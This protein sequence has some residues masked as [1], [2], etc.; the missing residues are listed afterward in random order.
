MNQTIL[1]TVLAE[2]KYRFEQITFKYTVELSKLLNNFSAKTSNVLNGTFDFDLEVLRVRELE[3]KRETFEK[4]LKVYYEY[5]RDFINFYLNNVKNELE[6]NVKISDFSYNMF[7]NMLALQRQFLSLLTEY[8]NIYNDLKQIASHEYNIYSA[9]YKQQ[10]LSFNTNTLNLKKDY[11]DISIS[12][13]EK[14]LQQKEAYISI[15]AENIYRQL[16]HKYNFNEALL[17]ME[18]QKLNY[19]EKLVSLLRQINNYKENLVNTNNSALNFYEKYLYTIDEFIQTLR[20][21]QHLD[22]SIQETE[23]NKRELIIEQH[24][25]SLYENFYNIKRNIIQIK[26]SNLATYINNFNSELQSRVSLLN[27]EFS[28]NILLNRKSIIL[29][30]IQNIQSYI[31]LFR[32]YFDRYFEEVTHLNRQLMS[33]YWEYQKAVKLSRARITSNIAE[34]FS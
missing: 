23:F 1:D 11:I 2:L 34:V 12:N 6:H 22:Y 20:Q 25:Q 18:N 24:K 21:L 33:S 5:Q 28:K 26:T 19:N 3:E 17:S 9:E 31:S 4:L 27:A 14:Y 16:E 13:E 29:D 7:E 30:D 8:Y 15:D 10:Y 32:S